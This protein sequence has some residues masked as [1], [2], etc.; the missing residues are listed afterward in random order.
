MHFDG[1]NLDANH[2]LTAC[3]LFKQCG[4]PDYDTALAQL[5]KSDSTMYQA[6][7]MGLLD[8]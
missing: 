6:Y 2:L 7:V 8:N 3:Q 1:K 4:S 5:E